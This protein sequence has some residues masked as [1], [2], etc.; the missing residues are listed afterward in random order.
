MESYELKHWQCRENIAI[1]LGRIWGM[2]LSVTCHVIEDKDPI[3]MDVK[4]IL[5]LMKI[6]YECARD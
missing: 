4:E 6:D 2:R 1:L 5:K 3:I